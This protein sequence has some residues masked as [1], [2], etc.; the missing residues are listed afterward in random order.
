VKILIRNYLHDFD[1]YFLEF[2]VLRCCEAMKPIEQKEAITMLDDLEWGPVLCVCLQVVHMIDIDAIDARLKLR[3]DDDLAKRN[4]SNAHSTL[5]D[6]SADGL[7]GPMSRLDREAMCGQSRCTKPY[8]I[9]K[10]FEPVWALGEVIL[11]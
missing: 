1:F 10:K 2:Q 7:V 11:F 5:P 3:I 9:R 8:A 4:C 6:M